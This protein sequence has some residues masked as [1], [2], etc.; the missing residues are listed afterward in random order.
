MKVDLITEDVPGTVF[1]HDC[2]HR[3]RLYFR[4]DN[5]GGIFWRRYRLTVEPAV[6]ER[7]ESVGCAG[8]NQQC[9]DHQ[10]RVDYLFHF[11]PLVK[12]TFKFPG[13]VGLV[14]VYANVA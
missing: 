12:V 13:L 11:V 14:L 4:R 9:G 1:N 6:R 10:Y 7:A 8:V 2:L 5:R 3:R